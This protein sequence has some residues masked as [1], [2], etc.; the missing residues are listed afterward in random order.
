ML[1]VLPNQKEKIDLLER[2]STLAGVLMEQMGKSQEFQALPP[3]H[4][5]LDVLQK[6]RE[7]LLAPAIMPSP[8]T[9]MQEP[10]APNADSLPSSSG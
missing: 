3:E 7:L 6:V 4:L 2:R 8:T 9:P 1:Y 10:S 5:L